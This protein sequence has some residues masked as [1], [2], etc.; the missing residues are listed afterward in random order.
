MTSVWLEVSENSGNAYDKTLLAKLESVYTGFGGPGS[1]MIIN[2]PMPHSLHQGQPS[3]LRAQLHQGQPSN[4]RAQKQVSVQ[5]DDDASTT[6]SCRLALTVLIGAAVV[7]SKVFPADAAYG[8]SE[9]QAYFGK[10]ASEN[11]N[12]SEK[13]LGAQLKDLYKSFVSEYPI[14][15]I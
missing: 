1:S 5:E 14:V 11:N 6:V 15:S 8:E 10:T 4:L 7:G 12:G 3:N 2:F 9:K 13:I